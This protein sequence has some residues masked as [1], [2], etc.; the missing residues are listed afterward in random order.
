MMETDK[1]SVINKNCHIRFTYQLNGD[2]V[3][4]FAS[5]KIPSLNIFSCPQPF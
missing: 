2:I 1:P 4:I 5:L 3:S